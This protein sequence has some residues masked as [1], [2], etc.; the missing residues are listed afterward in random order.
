MPRA[1][2]AA[3]SRPSS[4]TYASSPAGRRCSRRSARRSSA[5][6]S[7]SSRAQ[8]PRRSSSSSP[9]KDP[10]L[11]SPNC[12]A[13]S[14]LTSWQAS[15]RNS[16]R[17]RHSRPLSSRLAARGASYRGLCLRIDVVRV[18]GRGA[19]CWGSQWGSAVHTVTHRGHTPIASPPPWRLKR[20]GRAHR[21]PPRLSRSRPFWRRLSLTNG[22]R[23]E[24]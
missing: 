20:S 4:G 3:K 17:R 14:P 22:R 11:Q 2:P 6:A 9:R 19:R 15:G 10:R 13:C 18:R 23:D 7:R 8:A 21:A 16:R 5:C 12:S 1:A 24:P